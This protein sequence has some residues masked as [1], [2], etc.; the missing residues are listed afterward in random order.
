MQLLSNMNTSNGQKI[1][2][3]MTLVCSKSKGT[4]DN[5][6]HEKVAEGTFSPGYFLFTSLI[7]HPI[8][9]IRHLPSHIL[10]HRAHAR[11]R[12][13]CRQCRCQDGYYHLNHCLPS[14]SFHNTFPFFFSFYRRLRSFFLPQITQISQIFIYRCRVVAQL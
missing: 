13:Q 8:S 10:H 3:K 6:T 14:L 1:E 4:L 11:C 9:S 5:Y 2:K 12:A 7:S